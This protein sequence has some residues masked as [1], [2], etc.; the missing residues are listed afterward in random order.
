MSQNRREHQIETICCDT[1]FTEFLKCIPF[2]LIILETFGQLKEGAQTNWIQI[3]N[4]VNLVLNWC[5]CLT[6][7]KGI[8][9]HEKQYN[10]V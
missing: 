8:S 6:K 1:F 2:P 10:V 3:Q 5:F 4:F 7:P 9:S